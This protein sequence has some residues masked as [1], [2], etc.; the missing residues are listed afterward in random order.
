MPTPRRKREASPL[1]LAQF[2]IME[3]VALTMYR[4][5][6]NFRPNTSWMSD[7]ENWG[8]FVDSEL[9]FHHTSPSLATIENSGNR[10][11]ATNARFKKRIHNTNRIN[12]LQEEIFN[13]L[14][15]EISL[16]RVRLPGV[17][18][19]GSGFKPEWAVI[20][21]RVDDSG[22]RI[23]RNLEIID[24]LRDMA[25]ENISSRP[26]DFSSIP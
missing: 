17:V 5:I 20:L 25:I 12:V 1:F 8:T 10:F 9:A 2:H 22:E 14:A 7:L 16:E 15:A 24:R 3:K 23:L 13:L 6:P 19:Q 18:R 26:Q 4:I 21:G 11:I